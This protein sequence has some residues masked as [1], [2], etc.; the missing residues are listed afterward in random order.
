MSNYVAAD[1]IAGLLSMVIGLFLFYAGKNLA[2]N[3]SLERW[4]MK[5][6]T[7]GVIIFLLG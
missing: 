2:V 5:L 4:S 6:M 3:T 1:V 7:A